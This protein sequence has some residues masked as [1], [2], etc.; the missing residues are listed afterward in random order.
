[1]IN[2]LIDQLCN[3]DGT[4]AIGLGISNEQQLLDICIEEDPLKADITLVAQMRN[5][6]NAE[7]LKGCLV[8]IAN[9]MG[10]NTEDLGNAI[11]LTT[12]S[13]FGLYLMVND[14]N[15]IVSNKPYVDKNDNPT[16]KMFNNVSSGMVVNIPTISKLIGGQSKA[17]FEGSFIYQNNT[18]I[19]NLKLINAGNNIYSAIQDLACDWQNFS[20][21]IEK[22]LQE[23]YWSR[24]VPFEYDYDY[25]YS[26][27]L[28]R[29]YDFD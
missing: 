16:I 28:Y 24:G 2:E 7:E 8:D 23:K 6:S 18:F 25:D 13:S 14:N 5:H 29:D 19:F 4:I 10:I 1:M 26:D 15:F 21:K 27:S 9:K 3:I 12:A 22:A 20:D 11:K 17:G